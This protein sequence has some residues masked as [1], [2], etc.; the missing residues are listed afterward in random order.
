MTSRIDGSFIETAVSVAR[1]LI[2]TA[3]A[4]LAHSAARPLIATASATLAHSDRYGLC[5]LSSLL[6]PEY[7]A[8]TFLRETGELLQH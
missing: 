5:Y 4:T 6:C 8:S 1:P 7:A 3:S 2:A